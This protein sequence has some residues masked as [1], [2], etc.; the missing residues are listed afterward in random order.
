MEIK[1][2]EVKKPEM[3]HIR[4]LVEW[5]LDD[6]RWILKSREEIPVSCLW[7]SLKSFFRDH[8]ISVKG[9]FSRYDVVCSEL[10]AHEICVFYEFNFLTSPI[11]TYK[12]EV[13]RICGLHH[14]LKIEVIEGILFLSRY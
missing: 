9:T 6:R 1:K 11:G 8:G 14:C 13:D 2:K 7:D 5:S 10:P 12:T 4:D 3:A